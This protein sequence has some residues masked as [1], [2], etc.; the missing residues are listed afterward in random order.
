MMIE[1]F[2]LDFFDQMSEIFRLDFSGPD[3]WG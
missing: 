2:G 1:I 3:F